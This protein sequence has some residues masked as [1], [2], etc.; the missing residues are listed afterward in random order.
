MQ[1]LAKIGF[2]Q[3]YTYFTWR[4]TRHELEEY[5]EELGSIADYYRPNF[6]ANTPDILHEYLQHGGPG[7]FDA[8]LVLAATLSPS[9]GIY[10]GFEWFENEPV[11]AGSEEYADSE[12]YA[13]KSRSL[14]GPLLER[15]SLVNLIRRSYDA[16]EHI[17]NATFLDT[18][19]DD[20][21]AYF[22]RGRSASVIVCVN[23]NPRVFSEG[24]L[25][26]PAS[27]ELPASFQV[28]DLLDG[29]GYRWRTGD[30]YVLLSPG[31]SHIMRIVS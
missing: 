6:F 19:H 14:D 18:R 26:I 3:S 28:V 31:S 15:I 25:A 21:I 2:N 1:L 20:L 17:D 8:R 13:L 27:L 23:L 10:S 4:N 7:A 30:N 16:F 5:V 22:K 29:A 9:Y 24:L 12:K 11:R